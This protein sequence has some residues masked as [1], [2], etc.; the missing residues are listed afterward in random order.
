[1]RTGTRLKTPG[2]FES[3]PGRF[4][5][6]SLG[7]NDKPNGNL[8]VRGELRYDWYDGQPGFLAPAVPGFP[9]NQ[10]YGDNM[11]KNQ[12]LLGLHVVCQF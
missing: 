3:N 1:M 4:Y 6:T 5:E 12:F 2:P 11:N 7:V 9:P 8:T 10:P